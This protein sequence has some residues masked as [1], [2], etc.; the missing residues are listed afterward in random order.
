MSSSSKAY[1]GSGSSSSASMSRAAL[2]QSGAGSGEQQQQVVYRSDFEKAVITQTCDRRG[3]LRYPYGSGDE[4]DGWNVYWASVHTVR[5][6]FNPETGKRLSDWQVIN[7]F[8]NH[9]ELTRK[10][11]MVKNI[12]RYRKELEKRWN[13]AH[14]FEKRVSYSGGSRPGSLLKD[15]SSGQTSMPVELVPNSSVLV[16]MS[17]AGSSSSSSAPRGAAMNSRGVVTATGAATS[18]R[19]TSSSAVSGRV[20]LTGEDGNLSDT[21]PGESEEDALSAG[22]EDEEDEGDFSEANGELHGGSSSAA[23]INQD[24][25]PRS[26]SGGARHPSAVSSA[27]GGSGGARASASRDGTTI[28]RTGSAGANSSTSLLAKQAALHANM[29]C[30][31]TPKWSELPT[32]SEGEPLLD[33]KTLDFIP[34]TFTLPQDYSLFVEEFRR[35]ASSWIM[36]PIGKAQG[37][38]IFLVSRLNQVRKWAT[39]PSHLSL[40]SKNK[41]DVSNPFREPYIIS[42]YIDNPL[43]IGGKKFDLRVYVLV[44]S[45][46]PIRA[47]MY[48]EGFCRFCNVQYSTDVTELDN[49]FVHLTNVA[50]QKHAEEYNAKHGGKWSIRDLQFYLESLTGS[51]LRSKQVFRDMENLILVTLKSVQNS[52]INDKHCFE[53]YGVDILLDGQLKPWLLEVNASPSLSTTT[54]EDRILKSRLIHDVMNILEAEYATLLRSGNTSTMASNATGGSSGG[55]ASS[56][57]GGQNYVGNNNPDAVQTVETPFGTRT[58]NGGLNGAVPSTSK[59]SQNKNSATKMSMGGFRLLL[60]ESR[61]RKAR[62]RV[63]AE[64]TQAL[65]GKN[66]RKKQFQAGKEWR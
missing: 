21:L 13:F 32:D 51:R 60:D 31:L 55:N 54:H 57:G 3:W 2:H 36:K 20:D 23:N 10:D 62:E 33:P 17:G 53:L 56:G 35:T 7:H 12:K 50:I 41:D 4:E 18:K 24:R 11:L 64:Q 14:G 27:G 30:F 59:N 63:V 34:T 5:Q 37:K 45:F 46:R 39:Y 16:G 1:H 15:V 26:S 22:E 29:H 44:T 38:G 47:Y 58:T 28:P 40:S 52:M 61:L 65:N 6:M 48:Q 66:N 9:Y 19:P 8:P 42:R 49:V 43:L 25:G